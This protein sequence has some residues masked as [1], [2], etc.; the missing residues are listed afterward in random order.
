M[1]VV[2]WIFTIGI[3][4]VVPV[5]FHEAIEL[6]IMDLPS[7]VWLSVAYAILIV[8]VVVY[9]LNA[10]TLVSV[11][12]SVVG[13]FIYLQPIFATMTAILFFDEV[14]LFRHL[15]ACA[16]VFGGVWLETQ[17]PLKEIRHTVR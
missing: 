13:A 9:F 16:F 1:T 6:D 7:K 10:W 4:F 3:V 8:T 5:G 15:M 2:T 14:F 11:N 17:K 12:S